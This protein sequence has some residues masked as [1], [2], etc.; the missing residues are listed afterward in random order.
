MCGLV[1]LLLVSKQN[2]N[3]TISMLYVAQ[4]EPTEMLTV[5]N[6]KNK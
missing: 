4:C 6:Y 2:P 5:A 3:L 1:N